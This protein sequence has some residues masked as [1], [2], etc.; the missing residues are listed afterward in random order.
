MDF[1]SVI[2]DASATIPG[3]GIVVQIVSRYLGFD[4]G[5]LISKYL[6]LFAIFKA[7][8]YIFTQLQN[9]FV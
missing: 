3:Y 4:L 5:W 7:S 9:Y 6:V 2:N 8:A 1:S